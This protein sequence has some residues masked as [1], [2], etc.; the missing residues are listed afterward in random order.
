MPVSR[1]SS[2]HDN[3]RRKRFSLRCV[4]SRTVVLACFL[5][6]ASQGAFLFALEMC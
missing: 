4:T 2:L 6:A 5:L 3:V 1:N